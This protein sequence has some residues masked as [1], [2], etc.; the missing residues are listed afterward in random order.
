MVECDY[1][2][3]SF[4]D[5]DAYLGHLADE[6]RG[7][8]GRID[9]RRVADYTG[10]GDERDTG[11]YVLAGLGLLAAFALGAVVVMATGG[12]LP[13]LGS[14]GGGG[15]T[16]FTVAQDP[17]S[18]PGTIHEHGTMRATI[19]GDTIDFSQSQYQLQADCFHFE[20]GQDRIWHT[21]CRGVTLQWALDSVGIG[22]NGT[23]TALRFDGETYR[24]SAGWNVSVRVNNEP[25]EPGTYVLDGANDVANVERGDSVRVVV[26]QA[27]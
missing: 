13:F 20:A 27:E 8:L 3:Q 5:N 11:T 22:V 1:C 25:V 24:E 12:S 15:G 6:H 7:E 19:A 23:G 2:G 17:T 9:R 14:S 18:Q 10:E 4:D 26:R 16:G 21:H